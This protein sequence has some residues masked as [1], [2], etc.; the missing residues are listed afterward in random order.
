MK[1]LL[2]V[3]M[4][5]TTALLLC[6][7]SD[8]QFK[9]GYFSE[10]K[11]LTLFSDSKNIDS[12]MQLYRRD[13]VGADYERR[14][15]KFRIDDSLY[16]KDCKTAIPGK[17][18]EEALKEINLQ[19]QVLTNW[20]QIAQRMSNNKMAQLLY[21]YRQ[22]MYEAL[23][24]VIAED[25]YTLVLTIDALSKYFTPPLLDNLCIR[26]ALKLGLPLSKPLETLW[27]AAEAKAAKPIP[28][29][30]KKK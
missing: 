21:P 15:I 13:S 17:S 30:T 27:K 1:K 25:K 28:A 23:Q 11:T 12:L 4:V 16:K 22:K 9:I 19:G 24:Q 3:C 20:Y 2:F 5:V 8:A 14:T 18:C 10:E 26:V 7:T 29:S 6:H